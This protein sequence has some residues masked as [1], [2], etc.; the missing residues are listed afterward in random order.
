MKRANRLFLGQRACELAL[1]ISLLFGAF[2]QGHAKPMDRR[3]VISAVETWIRNVP[4]MN[5][6]DAAITDMRPY[7]ANGE[8]KAYIAQLSSG[9]FCLCGADNLVLPVYLYVPDGTFDE[10]NADY[11]YFLW[12]IGERTNRLRA[13]VA[14]NDPIVTTHQQDILSREA[15]WRDLATGTFPTLPT[16]GSFEA[17]TEPSLLVLDL[18]SRWSQGYPYNSQCPATYCDYVRPVVGCVA[19][20]MSQIMHY[21]KRPVVGNGTASGSY[22]YRWTEQ[23]LSRVLSA[24]PGFR[25][26]LGGRLVWSSGYLYM[27]GC[28]DETV[29]A[30]AQAIS[31]N[32]SYRS[33]LASLYGQL[34]V[35][36]NSYSVNMGA[37]I[38]SWSQMPDEPDGTNAGE[39][40]KLC[41]HVGVSLGMHY[42]IYGSGANADNVNNALVDHFRYDPD[43]THTDRN[44]ETMTE[45][46]QWMRPLELCGWNS[47][48]EGHCWVVL[49]YNKST[50]PNRS[51]LMHLGWGGQAA[52]YTC[53]NVPL[54]LNLS[55]DHIIRIAPKDV[56]KFV[57]ATSAGDGTPNDPYKD[58]KEAI[59]EAPSSAAL[60]FKAGSTN[61]TGVSQLTI[62]TPMT[63]KGKN[64]T[65]RQ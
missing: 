22:T 65:I 44:I 57:G 46:I 23:R 63:L 61:Y 60:I 26:A 3:S 16:K 62:S 35:V 33:A 43:A 7:Q 11:K 8:T 64:I 41:Y 5:R 6:P 34:S 37:A 17:M 59:L 50:D 13:A 14:A 47:E 1:C 24:D 12:E 2:G 31:S 42:G 4:G 21:W 9:G 18:T 54:G 29:Y 58:I 53:D 56:V 32:S 19:T 36:K 20:A 38:Y 45:E 10:E 40:A 39:V 51:F 52:W 30:E 55:Q 48:G 27:S 25:D 15:M 28:W 49:G